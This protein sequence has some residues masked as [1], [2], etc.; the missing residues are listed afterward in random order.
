MKSDK[1]FKISFEELAL[2][3]RKI[4]AKQ[5]PVTFEQALTQVKQLKENSKV[6]DTEK[7]NRI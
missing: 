6:K 2:Q 3:Q 1:N 7:K 5:P 4:L